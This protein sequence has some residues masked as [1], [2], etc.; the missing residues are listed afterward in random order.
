MLYP[1]IVLNVPE[2]ADTAE[3]RAAY[4]KGI[5]EFPPERNPAEFQRICAAYELVKDEAARARMRLFGLPLQEKHAG[6]AELVPETDEKRGRA[7]CDLW[8]E[9]I[10]DAI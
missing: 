8:M 3:I 6:L 7:G 1:Y 4:L 9:T 5:R 2:N 10:N